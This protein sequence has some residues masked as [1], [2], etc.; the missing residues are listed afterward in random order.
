M[1]SYQLSSQADADITSI[2]HFTI[3]KFGEAQARIYYDGLVEAFDFLAEHPRA[4]RLRDEIDP[5]V[6]AHPYQAHLIVYEIGD[7]DAV[8]ILRVPHSTMDWEKS[9]LT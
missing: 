7:G 2:I 9:P 5:P 1:A 4:A 8:T 3:E 6:R